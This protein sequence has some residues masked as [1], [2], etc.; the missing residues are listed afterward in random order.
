M[1]TQESQALQ[2]KPQAGP[3]PE[4]DPGEYKCPCRKLGR[5]KHG[6]AA[7]ITRLHK[8]GTSIVKLAPEI[9]SGENNR[10]QQTQKQ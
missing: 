6:A 8:T 1:K 9:K 3:A 10:K 5:L 2:T 4:S 7:A